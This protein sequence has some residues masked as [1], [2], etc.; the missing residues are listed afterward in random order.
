MSNRKN[1][2]PINPNA[3]RYDAQQAARQYAQGPHHPTRGT[4]Y[5][6]KYQKHEQARYHRVLKP[7]G[8]SAVAIVGGIGLASSLEHG[9]PSGI[10]PHLDLPKQEAPFIPGE[11]KQALP[12]MEHPS[13]T[14]KVGEKAVVMVCDDQYTDKVN[15]KT[16]RN[17]I[18]NTNPDGSI[19]RSMEESVGS[20]YRLS[21]SQQ[22]PGESPAG[23]WY[24]DHGKMEAAPTDPADCSTVLASVETYKS[25]KNTFLHLV[26]METLTGTPIEGPLN[27]SVKP[28]HK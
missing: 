28:N 18:V 17:N 8:W 1:L 14:L 13:L 26:P 25:G 2:P 9:E 12:N 22:L 16:T 6:E 19:R 5:N 7:L 23:T 27:Q 11:S 3:P 15:H 21:L 4:A 10:A 20:E 24:D